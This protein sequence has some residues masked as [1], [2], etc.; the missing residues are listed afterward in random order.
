MPTGG[1]NIQSSDA[2]DTSGLHSWGSGMGKRGVTE[3]SYMLWSK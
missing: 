2:A 3:R 1:E